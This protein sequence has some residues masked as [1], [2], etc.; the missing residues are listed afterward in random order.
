M[1]AHFDSKGIPWT[2]EDV[3]GIGSRQERKL[4]RLKDKIAART[5]GKQ[6]SPSDETDVPE[7]AT[8]LKGKPN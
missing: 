7:W 3:M 6:K 2:E 1:N 4:R 5:A 8:R